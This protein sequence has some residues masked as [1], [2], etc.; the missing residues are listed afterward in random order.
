MPRATETSCHYL[1]CV[2]SH[3]LENG[4]CRAVGVELHLEKVYPTKILG[5][6]PRGCQHLLEVYE[7][8]HLTP[9]VRSLVVDGRL[10]GLRNQR[11][12]KHMFRTQ[13]ETDYV[14]EPVLVLCSE[15]RPETPMR[16]PKS[17]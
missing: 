9:T 10:P 15:R 17:V 8:E 7:R 13:W 1:S 12:F 4:N 5:G 6:L 11:K 14:D 16:A 3:C 2:P